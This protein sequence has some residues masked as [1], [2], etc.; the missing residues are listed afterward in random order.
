MVTQILGLGEVAERESEI[1]MRFKRLLHEA[2]VSSASVLATASGLAVVAGEL[3]M[4]EPSGV[5]LPVGSEMPRPTL[6]SPLE[7]ELRLDLIDPGRCLLGLD[8]VKPDARP[9]SSSTLAAFSLSCVTLICCAARCCAT[10]GE[11][12]YSS[13]RSTGSCAGFGECGESVPGSGERDVLVEVLREPH[14]F[15]ESSMPCRAISAR[16]RSRSRMSS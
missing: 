15:P 10:S 13:S 9:C 12:L 3:M 8:S 6:L 4:G 7:L 14:E 5:I 1:E 16:K 11:D 2:S